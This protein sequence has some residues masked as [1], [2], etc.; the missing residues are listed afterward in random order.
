MFW[1]VNNVLMVLVLSSFQEL[2]RRETRVLGGGFVNL[3]TVIVEVV[4]DD[5]LANGVF[6]LRVVQHRVEPKTDLLVDPLEEVLLG[7]L[8]HQLVNVAQRVLF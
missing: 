6:G 1:L 3:Q 7:R 4:S 8:G 2:A 5:E